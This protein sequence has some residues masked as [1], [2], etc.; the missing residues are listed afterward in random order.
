[1]SIRG[2][3]AARV[4]M[5]RDQTTQ[6]RA[7]AVGLGNLSRPARCDEE[8]FDLAAQLDRFILVAE[9]GKR[10]RALRITQVFLAHLGD[11]RCV[12]RRVKKVA[13][14]QRA[15]QSVK[16]FRWQQIAETP[17]ERGLEVEFRIGA[18]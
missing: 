1:M 7:T 18:V 14:V 2:S 9:A 11:S 6:R 16:M 15:D 3:A 13:L 4:D 12:R 17:G 5:R 8:R 10:G